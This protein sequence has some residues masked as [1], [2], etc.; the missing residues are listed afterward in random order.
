MNQQPEGYSFSG[1]LAENNLEGFLYPS[2]YVL[3]RET[4]MSEVLSRILMDFES[5]V[6]S[7]MRNGYSSQGLNLCQ[8]V[9]LASI[10]ER[11]AMQDDEMPQIASVF[12]NR[13]DAGSTLASDPTVQYALGYNQEQHTWWTNPLTLQ[14]LKVDSPYNSYIYN[15]LPPGPISNPGQSALEA[16]AFPAQTPYFYFRSA[17]DGSGYHLF[18]ESFE[19]HVANE[20]P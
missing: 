14:D 1:C 11:E 15:G 9:T 6:T 10:V 7:E 12:Y 3:L 5:N 20:C 17:C 19:E 18:A 16:V 8:A 13:L 4:T 2:S